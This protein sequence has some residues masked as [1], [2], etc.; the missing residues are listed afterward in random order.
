MEI[1]SL[2][3]AITQTTVLCLFIKVW[4]LEKE[5]NKIKKNNN[6]A[7]RRNRW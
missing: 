6:R 3:L 1:L 7:N 5:L 4:Q 2:L